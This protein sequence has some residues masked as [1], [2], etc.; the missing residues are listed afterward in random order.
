MF[1]IERTPKNSWSIK[2]FREKKL[3]LATLIPHNGGRE[4]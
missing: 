4:N 2:A 3:G 1:E